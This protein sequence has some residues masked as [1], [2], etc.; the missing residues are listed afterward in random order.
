MAS[1]KLT[2]SV[3]WWTQ[4][5]YSFQADGNGLHG[6]KAAVTFPADQKFGLFLRAPRSYDLCVEGSVVQVDYDDVGDHSMRSF[7]IAWNPLAQK[8]GNGSGLVRLINPLFPEDPCVF[9]L[10]LGENSCEPA[11]TPS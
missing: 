3:T 8:Q 10:R 11:P 6:I 2:I 7:S 5:L 4:R 1:D 9:E